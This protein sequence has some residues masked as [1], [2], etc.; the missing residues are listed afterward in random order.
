MS[1]LGDFNFFE[2]HQKAMQERKK[3]QA[4]LMVVLVVGGNEHRNP[5]SLSS[6][7]IK[8]MTNRFAQVVRLEESGKEELIREGW[9]YCCCNCG[10]WS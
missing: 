9:L 2:D 10:C 8:Q 6:D 7:F 5:V 3:Q 4:S 1:I